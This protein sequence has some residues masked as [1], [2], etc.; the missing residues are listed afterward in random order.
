MS[1]RTFLS[2]LAAAATLA[3]AGLVAQPVA[4]A[5]QA[6]IRVSFADLNLSSLAGRATF[7]RRIE[8]AID[9][10]CGQP[11]SNLDMASPVWK[12]RAAARASASPQRQLAVA[13]AQRPTLQLAARDR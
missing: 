7:D 1:R 12:C 10:L 11:G 8:R 3:P 5:E 2:L 6:S 9:V 13:A 4:D